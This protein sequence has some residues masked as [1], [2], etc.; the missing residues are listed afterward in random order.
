MPPSGLRPPIP[1]ELFIPV[2]PDRGIVTP[3]GRVLLEIMAHPD[4]NLLGLTSRIVRFYAEPQ[5]RWMHKVVDVGLDLRP[6]TIGFAL[7]LL[8]NGSVG[9]EAA[10]IIPS[11]A[12]DE[13]RLADTVMSVVDA[14]SRTYG[15]PVS[16]RER[17]RLRSN[18]IISEA[19]RQLP[20]LVHLVT[21]GKTGNCYVTA[22]AEERLLSA[23]AD[24]LAA[25][26]DATTPEKVQTST[27]SM[28]RAYS[29]V[30]PLLK[31][32]GLSWERPEHTTHCLER[33]GQ[34]FADARSRG[35]R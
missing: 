27:T 35:R 34:R 26:D 2:G 17:T 31:S 21:R 8:I 16:E 29:R 24:S 13:Y 15:N 10:L 33:L 28:A 19:H 4:I 12:D 14:F 9:A 22:H 25:R 5:R 20:G 3:E 30:R 7:F 1:E 32:W 23:L 11:G 18:W 6:Q